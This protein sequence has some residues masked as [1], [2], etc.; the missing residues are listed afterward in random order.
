MV[1][2]QKNRDNWRGGI[3][4]NARTRLGVEVA[5]NE[6]VMGWVNYDCVEYRASKCFIERYKEIL[7]R[8]VGCRWANARCV[9]CSLL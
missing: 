6:M 4:S 7:R 9:G 8:K 5:V 2:V 1:C 3:V